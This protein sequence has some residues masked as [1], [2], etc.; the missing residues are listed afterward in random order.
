VTEVPE[1]P[2]EMTVEDA[3]DH[4]FANGG[5]ALKGHKVRDL[6]IGTKDA[7]KSTNILR[8]FANCG[9]GDDKR[10]TKI[11]LDAIEKGDLRFVLASEQE[12]E[13]A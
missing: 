11:V 6:V 5:D 9:V 7:K 3:L 13:T 12:T 8:S 4:V 1:E 10:A 2:K